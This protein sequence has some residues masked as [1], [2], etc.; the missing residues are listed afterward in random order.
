[1]QASEQIEL[2]EVWEASPLVQCACAARGPVWV[3]DR[4]IGAGLVSRLA[5]CQACSAETVVVLSAPKSKT[6]RHEAPLLSSY[7]R[8]G[9]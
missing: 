7:G 5:R 2:G 4:R 3:C 9:A 8:G 6:R 1:M